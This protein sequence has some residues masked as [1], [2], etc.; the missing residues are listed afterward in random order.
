MLADHW[1]RQRSANTKKKAQLRK[2]GSY[3]QERN[4]ARQRNGHR[5]LPMRI[6]PYIQ[7][8]HA[9][10]SVDHHRR[11][12]L[13]D[14]TRGGSLVVFA[15][16]MMRRRPSQCSPLPMLSRKR[17]RRSD[18]NYHAHRD[19][20]THIDMMGLLRSTALRVNAALA[21][22]PEHVSFPLLGRKNGA[23]HIITDMFANACMTNTCH[24]VKRRLAQLN[25]A[26]VCLSPSYDHQR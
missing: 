3:R 25:P 14:G 4:S 8:R 23:A 7:R 19:T 11:E 9:T 6:R 24:V 15:Q 2:G 5:S 10:Y 26:I 17:K 12:K 16:H 1:L 21:S 18:T 22:I 20:K 13:S